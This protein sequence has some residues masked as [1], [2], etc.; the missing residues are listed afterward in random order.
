MKRVSTLF[1]LAVLMAPVGLFAIER[2]G[3]TAFQFLKLPVGVRG[4]GMGGAFV[5]GAADASAV[6]WNPAGLGWARNKEVLF[7]HINL[8]ADIRYDNVALALPFSAAIGTFGLNVGV[9]SMGDF[10][11]RTAENPEGTGELVTAYDLMLGLSYSR[12]ISDRFSFGLSARY[13]REDLADFV[14]NGVTFD[15]GLLYQTDFRSMRLGMVIQNFGPDAGFGGSFLDLRTSTGTT[16]QP[17]ERE[18]ESAPMPITFK[19]GVMADLESFLGLQMGENLQ[20]NIVG[21]FEHPADNKERVN[22]GLELVMSQKL[23]L[24]GGYNFSHDTD[25]FT[26]GVGFQ[27]PMSGNKNLKIDYAYADQ[28]DLTDTSTFMNQ[29]HRFSLSF[30]F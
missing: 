2:V 1:V 23:A 25:T 24:R 6:Y 17:I 14:A 29:P 27:V 19:A 26:L 18:F 11:V 10:A 12:Q 20:G 28:G 16:G 13:V 3:T 21:Q 8:P 22:G 15:A 4:I 7:A 9:L 30:Q 5:A